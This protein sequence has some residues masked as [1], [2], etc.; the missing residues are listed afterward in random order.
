MPGSDF[1]PCL[2]TVWPL[3]H[4]SRHS[5][6]WMFLP[7]WLHLLSP[8]IHLKSRC[9]LSH[10]KGMGLFSVSQTARFTF[11]YSLNQIAKCAH[12]VKSYAASLILSC[13]GNILSFFG[14]IYNTCNKTP[15]GT[16]VPYSVTDYF[17]KQIMFPHFTFILSDAHVPRSNTLTPK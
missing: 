17:T 10:Y 16:E 6:I 13:A 11:T 9:P 2:A 5:E 8:P 14:A 4:L 15:L 7:G 12:L 1:S 3:E